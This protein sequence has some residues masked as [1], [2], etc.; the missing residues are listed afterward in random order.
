MNSVRLG[1]GK[2]MIVR[3]HSVFGTRRIKVRTFCVGMPR[4]FAQHPV[5]V[6][7]SFTELRKRRGSFLTVYDD[8][9]YLTI[10]RGSEILYDS[11]SDVPV[12][13]GQWA[14]IAQ[15]WERLQGVLR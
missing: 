6:T 10:E 1:G 4:P 2:A 13:M 8:L 11:R 15:A 14:A 7:V 12:D 9:A 5:S 3:H